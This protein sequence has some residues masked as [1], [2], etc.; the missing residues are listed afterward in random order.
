MSAIVNAS[1]LVV[2]L[3]ALWVLYFFFWREHRIDTFRQGLFEIRDDLFDYAASGAIKLDDPAYTTLRDLSNGLIRFA[4]TLTF[5]RVLVVVLFGNPPRTNRM[6]LWMADIK[7]REP[8]VRDRLLKAHTQ[9]VKISMLR[10]VAWSPLAW[11]CLW[12]SIVIGLLNS[13][14]KIKVS[15]GP[16]KISAVL[17]QEVLEQG[18][19][20][21]DDSCL[22][23]V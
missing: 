8:E 11:I 7:T 9:I 6:D 22:A 3:F 19:L 17:E 23:A 14:S 4:H 20:I 12:A 15:R 1:H 21:E 10:V 13:G 2:G 18:C 16:R 5:T